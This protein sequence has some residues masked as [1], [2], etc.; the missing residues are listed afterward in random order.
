MGSTKK[1]VGILVDTV[2]RKIYTSDE[3]QKQCVHFSFV[4]VIQNEL[5]DV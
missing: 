5:D 2:L 1:V 3:L 4:K